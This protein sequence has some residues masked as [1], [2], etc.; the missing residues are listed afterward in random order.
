MWDALSDRF[1]LDRFSGSQPVGPGGRRRG[2]ARQET[3]SLLHLSRCPR[4]LTN[5][6]QSDVNHCGEFDDR[7]GAGK[8]VGVFEEF[9]KRKEAA[10]YLSCDTSIP[11]SAT[12]LLQPARRRLRT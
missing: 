12:V 7:N 9:I 6:T 4:G 2:S 3:L 11:G 5:A 10:I 1:G 8:R